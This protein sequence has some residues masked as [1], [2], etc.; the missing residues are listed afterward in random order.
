MNTIKIHQK[1]YQHWFK[2]NA[3]CFIVGACCI[4]VVIYACILLF[5]AAGKVLEYFNSTVLK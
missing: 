5:P 2:E 4:G 1:K 3:L